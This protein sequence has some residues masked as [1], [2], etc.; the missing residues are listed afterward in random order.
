MSRQRKGSDGSNF[1]VVHWLRPIARPYN[2]YNSWSHQNRQALVRVKEA[3]DV[4]GKQRHIDLG[5]PIDSL[6]PRPI[7]RRESR[8]SLAF[9]SAFDNLFVPRSNVQSVPATG[10]N[11]RIAS[12]KKTRLASPISSARQVF[13]APSTQ[14]PIAKVLVQ[15]P[16]RHASFVAL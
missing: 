6:A 1:G 10:T 14:P 7:K 15:T 2:S 8:V 5:D 3:K 16:D 12:E 13:A 11:I 9:Q 4:S